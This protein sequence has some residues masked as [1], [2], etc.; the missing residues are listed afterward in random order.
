MMT[1]LMQTDILAISQVTRYDYH[2]APPP[3]VLCFLQRAVNELPEGYY[4][5]LWSMNRAVS[6]FKGDQFQFSISYEA[7][8]E[9]IVGCLDNIKEVDTWQS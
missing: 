5:L 6:I 9:N 2:Y 7:I 8:E 1:E 3:I 4:A